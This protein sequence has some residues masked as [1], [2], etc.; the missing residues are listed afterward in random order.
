MELYERPLQL[1]EHVQ[2]M[3]THWF[4]IHQWERVGAWLQL[5]DPF[6]TTPKLLEGPI[7]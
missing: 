5:R 6:G 2:H 7:G 1:H 4:T 3:I